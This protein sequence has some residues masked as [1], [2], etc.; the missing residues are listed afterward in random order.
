MM[1]AVPAA[2]AGAAATTHASVF[3]GSRISATTSDSLN[4][5]GYAVTPAT[6]IT[7]VDSTFT[8]PTASNVPPGFS[9]TWTGIGGYTSS[10]LIQA[11]VSENNSLTTAV[12]GPQYYAWYEILPA[13]E[14]QITGCTGDANCTVSPGD[15]VSVDIHNTGGNQWSVSLTDSGHWTYNITLSYASTESSA[16]WIQ[17]APTLVVQTIPDGVGT[18]H[19]G[20]TSTFTENGTT[21]T[22]GSSPTA[23]TQIEESPIGV[24]NEAT[25]SNLG[26]DGQSFNVCVYAQSCAAP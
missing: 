2:T 9:A 20:G 6:G 1:V 19:F 3:Q 12:T 22:I 25:T 4:W 17:E 14:T 11:G 7:A 26:P 15:T 18:V 8:V 5:A 24:V 23:A 16:E 13:S 10:D 21:Y